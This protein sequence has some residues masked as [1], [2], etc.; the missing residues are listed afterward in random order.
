MAPMRL[1]VLLALSTL[2]CGTTRAPVTPTPPRLDLKIDEAYL[3]KHDYTH[4]PYATTDGPAAFCVD[5]SGTGTKNIII[6]DGKTKTRR[7]I[8][9]IEVTNFNPC[10]GSQGDKEVKPEGFAAANAELAARPY[11]PAKVLI[12]AEPYD[13]E[14][15]PLKGPAKLANG[16]TLELVE[17]EGVVL[18]R[19]DQVIETFH[20]VMQRMEAID[21][22]THVAL[23]SHHRFEL[24][25]TAAPVP[26]C[27]ARLK[28]PADF[29]R[30]RSF[31][32]AI[33]DGRLHNRMTYDD[34]F[35]LEEQVRE[36]TFLKG[37]LPFLLAA[38]GAFTG[39]T[40][41]DPAMNQFFYAEDAAAWLPPGCVGK[42]RSMKTLPKY[43]NY[44]IEMIQ[45]LIAG[46]YDSDE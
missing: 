26:A 23:A 25:D 19:G 12:F 14:V 39:Q 35:A 9:L 24:W 5:V 34:A 42:I 16:A 41:P 30:T 11:Q 36:G 17:D 3:E 27:P 43:L 32:N 1:L 21:L 45:D 6:L 13:E 4:C 33:C 29:E 15:K 44:D 40:F 37:D 20:P 18:R 28:C 46:R 31:L 38:Y 8:S 10:G 2:A 7:D 22:G